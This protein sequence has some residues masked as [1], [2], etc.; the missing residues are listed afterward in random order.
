MIGLFELIYYRQKDNTKTTGYNRQ[1]I[2]NI[3]DK[4][5]WMRL[6]KSTE[7]FKILIEGSETK[8]H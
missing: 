4:N 2:L 7:W 8:C 6:T 1:I 3:Y 5:H